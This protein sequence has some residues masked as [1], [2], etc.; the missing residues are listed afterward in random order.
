MPNTEN[1]LYKSGTDETSFA[2]FYLNEGNKDIYKK[3]LC[4]IFIMGECA[5][6]EIN[7]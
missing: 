4:I 3:I 6:E 5:F 1:Y 2:G 7:L